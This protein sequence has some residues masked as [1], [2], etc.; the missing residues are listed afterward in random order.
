M[1]KNGHILGRG[2]GTMK[3]ISSVDS[4][5]VS[6]DPCWLNVTI[7]NY[8]ARNIKINQNYNHSEAQK[9]HIAP[10]FIGLVIVVHYQFKQSTFGPQRVTSYL[11]LYRRLSNKTVE[12]YGSET[13]YPVFCSL[14][15][16]I[17]ALAYT[18]PGDVNHWICIFMR[19]GSN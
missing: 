12:I 1:N 2:D 13:N 18:G 4:H 17:C 15:L 11:S 19:L 7:I 3:N 14:R 6:T 8:S 16:L 9:S 5:S 10:Y